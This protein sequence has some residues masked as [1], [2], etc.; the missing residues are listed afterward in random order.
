[1]DYEDLYGQWRELVGIET[2]GCI[3]VR[4]DLYIAWRSKSLV[5]DPTAELYSVMSR[6]LNLAR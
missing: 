6:V 2:N 3:L 1:M 5:D 4:P